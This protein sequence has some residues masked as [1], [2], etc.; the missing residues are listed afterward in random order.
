GQGAN[1]D[2]VVASVKAYINALN[3]LR[4]RKEHPKKVVSQGM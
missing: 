2:I 3:K 4:W 1:T